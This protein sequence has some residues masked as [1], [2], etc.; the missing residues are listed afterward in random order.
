MKEHK[1][2]DLHKEKFQIERIALFSDA[3]FAIAITLLIIEIRVP[4]VHDH[5]VTDAILWD[6]L[7]L[8][9]PKFVGFLVSFFVIGLYWLVHHR[10]FRYVIHIN[11]KLLWNN[12]L[13]LLPIVVMPFSTAVLSEYYNGTLRL[14]LAVYMTNICFTGFFS[15]RLWTIIG[16]PAYHLSANL[17]PVILK[18]YKS[19]ALIIPSIFI[20]IFLLSFINPWISYVIPPFLPLVTRLIKRHYIKKY[21]DVMKTHLQ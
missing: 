13:F 10:M 18:Y 1:Q 14:P 15:Y 17:N 16:N 6:H 19:R 4:E 12:L 8:V 21:P 5:H 7:R 3:V 20:C 11:Q 9:I 2:D